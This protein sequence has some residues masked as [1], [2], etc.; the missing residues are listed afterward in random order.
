MH[1]GE[2]LRSMQNAEFVHQSRNV[3]RFKSRI[4]ISPI[5]V[6][7]TSE[8]L[9]GADRKSTLQRYSPASSVVMFSTRSSAGFELSCRWARSPNCC[10]ADQRAP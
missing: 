6:R 7:L 8:F 2:V 3:L 5:T 1:H 9:V 4:I 10:L